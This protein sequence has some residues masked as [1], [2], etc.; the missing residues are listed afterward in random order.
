M[1]ERSFD[2]IWCDCEAFQQEANPKATVLSIM[3]EL[4][5]KIGL[6]KALDTKSEIPD[7]QSLKVRMM[8]EIL[9]TLTNLSV[10]DNINV[11]QALVEALQLRSITHL[12]RKHTT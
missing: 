7:R 9:L 11:Y 5:M 2:L 6:Y 12:D 10:V 1:T 3:E 8:G 4:A